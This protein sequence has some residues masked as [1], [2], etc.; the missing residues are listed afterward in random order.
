MSKV[1]ERE[2]VIRDLTVQNSWT[3]DGA[4]DIDSTLDVTGAA[5]LDSTL[6]VTG[7]TSLAA[8]STTAGTVRLASQELTETGAITVT[9]GLVMLNH[10]STVIAAT[11]AAPAVGDV[12]WIINSSASGTAAHTVT[13]PAGVTW[14]GTN[15]VA[16]LDAPN[17]ALLVIAIS[18]T[19]FYIVVNNGTVSFGNP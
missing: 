17:E 9:S 11:K 5:T 2:M 7:V 6:D 15:R 4:L 3:F 16:T 14:D 1:F 13:L 12:L 19:R 10:A 8:M 18:A